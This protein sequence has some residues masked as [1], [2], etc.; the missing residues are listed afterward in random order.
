[1]HVLQHAVAVV[2]DLEAEQP[3][4]ALA[5]RG[6]QVGGGEPALEQR[7]LEVEPQRD[8]QVVGRLVGLRPD[9]R[10][11]D[12]V[13]AAVERRVVH[14]AERVREVP[15]QPR[16]QPRAERPPAADDVLPQPALGLVD[17]QR[18]ASVQRR[19]AQ[20][21][22]E[23][24]VVEAV[25]ELVQ[26]AVERPAEIVVA[27]ARGD[28]DVVGPGRLRRTGAANRR[29]ARRRRRTRPR[30]APRPAARAGRRCRRSRAG[31]P[32]R[33]PRWRSRPPAPEA[34]P[35]ASRTA[36]GSRPASCRARSRRAARRRGAR[37][38]R[39]TPRTRCRSSTCRESASRKRAKS[40][41]SCASSQADVAGGGLARH[42][43]GQPLGDASRLL[44][45]APGPADQPR[46]VG[47]GVLPGRPGLERLQ[48]PAR[49]AGRRAARARSARASRAGPPA[50]AFPAGGM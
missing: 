20:R 15:L 49:A 16:Q 40:S 21:R 42:V 28:A 32:P 50:R 9:Q 17:A 23:V 44:V 24:G 38:R 10:A 46:V 11:P 12:A 37:R 3:V 4:H 36:A 25:A 41:F 22:G 14:L 39:S 13:E 5:P 1:M 26:P 29:G 7:E 48:Q 6:R 35:R 31:R 2:R 43:D 47:V 34:R 27:P 45:V 19:A 30:R 8:V 18:G 33:R